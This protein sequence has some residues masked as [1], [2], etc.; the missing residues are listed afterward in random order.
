MES[1]WAFNRDKKSDK[2]LRPRPPGRQKPSSKLLVV[3]AC[4]VWELHTERWGWEVGP[5]K[6][7]CFV[8]ITV[9]ILVRWT[10][11]CYWFH[12]YKCLLVQTKWNERWPQFC[13]LIQQQ[14]CP[15]ACCGN[16]SQHWGKRQHSILP[17]VRVVRVC[18]NFCT[19]PKWCILQSGAYCV[20]AAVSRRVIGYPPVVKLSGAKFRRGA[21]LISRLIFIN[22]PISV[23]PGV[24]LGT[25]PPCGQCFRLLLRTTL[26]NPSG[27]VMGKLV[28]TSC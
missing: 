7:P 15:S 27:W 6:T 24:W 25:G 26:S 5:L 1:H 3:S 16:L 19:S 18:A 4:G 23:N 10:F 8:H 11:E 17:L 2:C 20:S 9:F 21:V 12:V 28:H 13:L 14:H 22:Y